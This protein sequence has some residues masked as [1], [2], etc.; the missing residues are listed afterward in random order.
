MNT[1]PKLDLCICFP[2]DFIFLQIFYNSLQRIAYLHILYIAHFH[3]HFA[4]FWLNGSHFCNND[5]VQCTAK[6]PKGNYPIGQKK[7]KNCFRPC[8]FLKA[9]TCQIEEWSRSRLRLHQC[10][11]WSLLLHYTGV[12]SIIVHTEKNLKMV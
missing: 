3:F 11:S 10:G 8:S 2:G 1:W 6:R 12:Y 7:I 9:D 5:T 4:H